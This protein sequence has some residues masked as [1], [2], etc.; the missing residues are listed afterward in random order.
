MIHDDEDR[1]CRD[2]RQHERDGEDAAR[3]GR[4]LTWSDERARAHRASLA[5]Q[6]CDAAF[7]R[8]YEDQLRRREDELEAEE[9]AERRRLQAE[10]DERELAEND[11]EDCGDWLTECECEQEGAES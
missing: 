7:L 3:F 5:P 10:R 6:G 4:S 11:C 1:Y 2:R 9:A 8:G